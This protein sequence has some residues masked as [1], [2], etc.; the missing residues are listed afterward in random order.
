MNYWK[1]SVCHFY[2][3]NFV[4]SEELPIM[5]KS[6]ALAHDIDTSISDKYYSVLDSVSSLHWWGEC[7]IRRLISVHPAMSRQNYRQH[8]LQRFSQCIHPLTHSSNI[9][10]SSV[11]LHVCLYVFTYICI[12]CTMSI[13]STIEFFVYFHGKTFLLKRK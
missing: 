2:T 8:L 1:I 6:V 7:K 12:L 4:F 5:C 9:N 10:F 3:S 13:V 11:H